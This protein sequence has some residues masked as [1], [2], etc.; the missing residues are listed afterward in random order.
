MLNN[1]K[2]QRLDAFGHLLDILDELR[3]KCPWDRV[4]TN[5]SLRTNTIEETYE[6]C[7]ALIRDDN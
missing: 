3:V 6:L 2:Q 5:E 1:D 4:Q 7:D